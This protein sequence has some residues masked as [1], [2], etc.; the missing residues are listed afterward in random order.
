MSTIISGCGLVFEGSTAAGSTYEI[1]EHVTV[2]L[3]ESG[4]LRHLGQ[5]IHTEFEAEVFQVLKDKSTNLKYIQTDA[6]W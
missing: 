4:G 3:P 1:F 6:S 5:V 2:D